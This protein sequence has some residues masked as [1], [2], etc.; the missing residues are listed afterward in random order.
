M[1]DYGSDDQ[2]ELAVS[3]GSGS[4]TDLGTKKT[5]EKTWDRNGA[6]KKRNIQSGCGRPT[7]TWRT[8]DSMRA[9]PWAGC[10][11][12]GRAPVE[13]GAEV[14]GAYWAMGEVSSLKR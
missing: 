14:L 11:G 6:E 12:A 4:D 9:W 7:R 5:M 13:R 3:D 8:L 10:P 2:A 1:A